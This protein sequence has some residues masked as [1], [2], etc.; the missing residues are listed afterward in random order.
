MKLLNGNLEEIILVT[1]LHRSPLPT[2]DLIKETNLGKS[3][4]TKQGIYRVLRKLKKEEKVII[5]RSV[6]SIN[7]L[8]LVKWS[9]ALEKSGHGISLVGD[10]AD[11]TEKEKISLKIRSLTH[12]DQIWSNIFLK[13]EPKMGKSSRL[14]LYNPHDWFL[15]LREE[16]EKIHIRILSARRRK[17][18]LAVHGHTFLDKQIMK[19]RRGDDF[20]CSI[21][22]KVN[23]DEY[24][25]VLEDYVLKIK[26][27]NRENRI[28]ES[29]F[30]AAEDVEDAKSSMYEI[31]ENVEST[32]VI[33][34]NKM[35]AAKWRK[36]ISNEFF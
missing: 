13:I 15:L 4:F 26:L 28:I 12:L 27:G 33:E 32:L 16:T 10:L 8:W 24:I 30:E 23:T 31:D 19:N 14:F 20:H 1:L 21:N 25:A 36:R 22:S 3:K 11:L 18:F 29:I 6:I 2:P 9:D 7:D 35:K 17:T 5:Y 34:K